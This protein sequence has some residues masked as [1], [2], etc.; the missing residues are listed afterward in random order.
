MKKILLLSFVLAGCVHRPPEEAVLAPLVTQFMQEPLDPSIQP[1]YPEYIVFGDEL[2]AR[3]FRRLKD[4]PRYRIVPAG[5]AF[6]CSPDVTPCP[7]PRGLGA[8]VDWLKGDSAVAEIDRDY[9]SGAGRGGAVRE[10][11][12]ILLI[13]RN[14]QWK[15]E[16][17]LGRS[18]LIPG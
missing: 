14:G 4:D 8:H 15:I 2:T 17:V 6:V 5:K 11:E 3:V 13:R 12:Q 18:Y 16:K 10:S 7:S 9:A 1:A